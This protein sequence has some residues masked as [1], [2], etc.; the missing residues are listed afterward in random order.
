MA[1]IGR[2]IIQAVRPKA[3]VAPLQIGLAAQ[4]HHLYRSRFLIA[5][6]TPGRQTNHIVLRM[7]VCALHVTELS[8]VDIVDYRF[9]NYA[10]KHV[11]FQTFPEIDC[12][13][14]AVDIFSRQHQVRN[15]FMA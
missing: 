8:R 6:V 15:A 2:L 11:V 10:C 14:L 7:N 12:S 1:S 3:V 5:A 9:S 13:T 4:L